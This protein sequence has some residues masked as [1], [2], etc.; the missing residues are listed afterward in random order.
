MQ[1]TT[2][3]AL[4]LGAWSS[5]YLIDA[6]FKVFFK[7]FFK[8]YHQN[9]MGFSL[10]SLLNHQIMS[11]CWLCMKPISDIFSTWTW[12]S[13]AIFSTWTW[14]SGAMHSPTCVPA[15]LG[16]NTCEFHF[17]NLGITLYSTTCFTW[18][19]L[20]LDWLFWSSASRVAFS[21]SCCTSV[22]KQRLH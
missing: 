13:E 18:I 9:L 2:W 3:I 6:F 5:L 7:T 12:L 15:L 1:Q 20:N 16:R 14:L 10:R 19:I 11:R 4:I 21:F 17:I 22:F 8:V